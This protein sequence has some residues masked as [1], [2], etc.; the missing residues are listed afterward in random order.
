[1]VQTTEID[2]SRV[3]DTEN[4]IG[5]KFK[6]PLLLWQALAIE[7]SKKPSDSQRSGPS[8]SPVRLRK[9]DYHEEDRKRLADLGSNTLDLILVER[10]YLMTKTSRWPNGMVLPK[11]EHRLS[12]GKTEESYS[13]SPHA[14]ETARHL[15]VCAILIHIDRYPNPDEDTDVAVPAPTVEEL[16]H[17]AP[18]AWLSEHGG[19][20]NDPINMPEDFGPFV[21]MEPPWMPRARERAEA[22][23][24]DAAQLQR[25]H[26]QEGE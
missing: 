6:R 8:S 17:I 14:P 3:R 12:L 15:S 18:R 26:P 25:T 5:Y 23:M 7:K 10:C 9:S 22:I 11:P 20:R 4:M 16:R 13:L 2:F 21:P 24:A 1:M 19:H